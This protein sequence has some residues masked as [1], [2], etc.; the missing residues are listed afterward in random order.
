MI[1]APLLALALVLAQPSAPTTRIQ[2]GAPAAVGVTTEVP[3]APAVLRRVAVIGASVSAGFGL[4]GP[5]GAPVDLAGVLARVLRVAP[6]SVAGNG[7]LTFFVDPDGAGAGRVEKLLADP[8]TLVLALD[9]LFW[10]GYGTQLEDEEHVARLE[11][12]LALLDRLPCEIVVGDLP[13]MAS[14]LE[15]DAPMLMASQ[16]PARTALRAM[17]A[18]LAAW[19]AER[20]RVHVV[21]L[22]SFVARMFAGDLVELRGNRWE[23]AT[24]RVLQRDLLHPTLEGTLGVVLLAMDALE[25]AREDVTAEMFRWDVAELVRELSPPEPAE[26]GADHDLE[27]VR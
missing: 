12:G 3:P 8:P 23:D 26:S 25:V 5:D 27:P 6:E 15:S 22:A 11:R 14:A 24:E 13:D 21:P 7:S 2:S 19:A 1:V 20:P 10:F 9:F 16:V 4:T 18:R 17:N